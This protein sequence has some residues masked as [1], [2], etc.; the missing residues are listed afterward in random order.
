MI[1]SDTPS[2]AMFDPAA[3]GQR[4]AY[5]AHAVV[6]HFAR[7]D[8]NHPAVHFDTR[9]VGKLCD[10]ANAWH[11]A[12][13]LT[14]ED[15]RK[16]FCGPL[17]GDATVETLR[18]AIG[19]ASKAKSYEDLNAAAKALAAAMSTVGLDRW[20]GTLGKLAIKAAGK[21]A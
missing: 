20:H 10:V 19:L 4:V 11:G 13:Q 14:T 3:I 16:R 12:E 5:L 7:A 21:P 1:P 2:S 6:G 15:F 8:R 18:K 17:T 9:A